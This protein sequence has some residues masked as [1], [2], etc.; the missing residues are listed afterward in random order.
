MKALEF[1]KQIPPFDRLDSTDLDLVFQGL[2]RVEVAEGA[3]LLHQ[4]GARSDCL[5][6]IR[7][8]TVELRAGGQ[9]IQVLEAGDMFGFPSIVGEEAPATDVVAVEPTVLYRLPEAHFRQ[10][11]DRPAFAHYF[12]RSLSERLRSA[13]GG[14]YQLP[15]RG[16]GLPV[17]HLITRTPIFVPPTATVQEAAQLM[18]EAN[19][20][21]VLVA[22]EPPGI[23]TDR[24]LR[25]RVLAAG[26]GPDTL[27]RQV[28][29]RPLIAVDA[30]MPVHGAIVKMLEEH[31]HHL[32]L[33]EE[34]HIVGL[35]SSTDLLR[36]QSESP[37]YLQRQLG[38]LRQP[39]R[40][41][42][43]KGEITRAIDALYQGGVAAP[44]IG[45]IITTLNDTLIGRLVHQ[46]EET[47]GPAPVPFAWIVFGSE[48]RSEQM[49]LTDQDNALVY[50][51]DVQGAADYF[52]EVAAFVVDRLLQAGFPPCPGGYMAT[53]WCKSLDEWVAIFEG[54]VLLPEPKALME[55]GI[56]F[57]FRPVAGTLS[58]EA[59]DEILAGAQ[60]QGI[61]LAHLMQAANEFAPPLGLFNRIR[62]K[63]GT[64]DL[65]HGGI[66]PVVGMARAL[67]LA[68]G[69]RE[70]S[71]L[72]RLAAAVQAGRISREGA[73]NL[74]GAFQFFLHIR[75]RQQLAAIAAGSQPDNRIVLKDLTTREQRLLKD[76]FVMVRQMQDAITSQ[77]QGG[78]L[79]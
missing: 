7:S 55:A 75:L 33:V 6:I 63:D 59:L 74:A 11:L 73:D 77:L 42:R 17:K 69:S 2:Q 18:S 65:K 48:G 54:W 41:A 39:A 31:I 49:L 60:R 19:T 51:G 35:I 57:D 26:L 21:S 28:M 25:R 24:D 22:D 20:S 46:A 68:A 70:R 44:Q 9:I 23:L 13:T 53:N 62:S 76:A 78:G 10:L 5:S 56:F 3:V 4:G 37:I 38:D 67:A 14:Q 27:V 47:L 66:A 50:A 52:G 40:L 36:H 12:L 71:T 15:D 30:E 72:E 1:V 8:G 45:R 16:L 61:F 29:S 58:L 64:I 34:G 32:A 43:Y 79:R